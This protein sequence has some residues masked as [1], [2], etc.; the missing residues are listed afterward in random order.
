M[1]RKQQNKILS[2]ILPS[3]N[4]CDDP[5]RLEMEVHAYFKD[6]FTSSS[7]STSD[8]IHLSPLPSLPHVAITKLQVEVSEAEILE[9]LKSIKSYS[10][11]GLDGFP[12][13]FFK[14]HW[15]I[16]KDHVITLIKHAFS[17]GIIEPY[18]EETLI[19]LIPKK[20]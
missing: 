14:R 12:V 11:H 17:S 13:I 6:L 20:K 5:V 15:D 1:K 3:G 9:T 7:D 18:I 19:T 2:L 4:T 16:V 10:S 8:P